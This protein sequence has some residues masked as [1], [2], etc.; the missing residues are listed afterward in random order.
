MWSWWRDSQRER[1]CGKRRLRHASASDIVSLIYQF[2]SNVNNRIITNAIAA[3]MAWGPV[4]LFLSLS[5]RRR[6]PLTTWDARESL[7][8][9]ARRAVIARDGSILAR[10][11]RPSRCIAFRTIVNKFRIWDTH[12]SIAAIFIWSPHLVAIKPFFLFFFITAHEW[13]ILSLNKIYCL[14]PSLTPLSF[15]ALFVATVLFPP[16]FFPDTFGT[17]NVGNGTFYAHIIRV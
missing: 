17:R 6:G 1:L 4:S 11:S 3:R 9:V 2:G 15:S 12:P 8:V 14:F 13:L 16:H 5:F 7:V 10:F